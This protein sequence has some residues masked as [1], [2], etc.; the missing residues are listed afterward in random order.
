MKFG[1]VIRSLLIAEHDDE[2]GSVYTRAGLGSVA[3]LHLDGRADGADTVPEVCLQL[4]EL[5]DAWLSVRSPAIGESFPLVYGHS[6]DVP[7]VRVESPFTE[8]RFEVSEV[9]ARRENDR[10]R[11]PRNGHLDRSGTSRGA[12][13]LPRERTANGVTSH[14]ET[15]RDASSPESLSPKASDG[16]GIGDHGFGGS[17]RS[18]A[19][20]CPLSRRKRPRAVSRTA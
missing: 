15:L 10:S 1:I 2:R 9:S 11:V 12:R 18:A 17:M 5:H 16:L 13:R 6:L 7:V 3:T 20:S 14:A 19:S 4:T 8:Q